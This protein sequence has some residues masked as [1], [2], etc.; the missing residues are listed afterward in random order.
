VSRE[1]GSATVAAAV[2][3]VVVLLATGVAAA[4]AGSSVLRARAVAAADL[5]ALAAAQAVQHAADACTQATQLALAN[6][7]RLT[8]CDVQGQMVRVVVVVRGAVP[9]LGTDVPLQLSASA[10]AGPAGPATP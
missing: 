1:R 3:M 8:S 7:A 4:W 2:L 10:Q 9:L 5:A 6:G